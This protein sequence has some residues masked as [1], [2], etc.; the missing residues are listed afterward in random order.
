MDDCEREAQERGHA[1]GYGNRP[2]RPFGPHGTEFKGHLMDAYQ[3][4]FT[5]GRKDYERLFCENHS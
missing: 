5:Q 4:G 1:D 2:F 3:R